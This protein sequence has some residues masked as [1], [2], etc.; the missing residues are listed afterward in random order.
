MA[1][2]GTVLI[3]ARG[4]SIDCLNIIDGSLLSTWNCPPT[5][6]SSDRKPLVPTVELKSALQKSELSSVESVLDFPPPAKKRRLST[7][8]DGIPTTGEQKAL[9]KEGKKKQNNRSD[10]VAS[11]LESPAVIALAVTQDGKHVVAVTGEDKCIRVFDCVSSA[12][13]PALKQLSQR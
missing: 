2:L 12:G 10:A 8:G 3:A 5:R 4:S 13:Q 11:G 7:D 6:E 9:V 1:K